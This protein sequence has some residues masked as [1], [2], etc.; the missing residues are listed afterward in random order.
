MKSDLHSVEH[1]FDYFNESVRD[2]LDA[3]NLDISEDTALYLATLLTDRARADRPAPD[4][5]TLAGIHAEAA[6]APPGRS[7]S[8][9][10]ELGDR[11]LYVL[12]CFRQQ[13]DRVRRPV[14]PAY[15]EQMGIA[16]Y[17]QCDRVLKTW[18]ADAFGPVFTDLSRQFS[19]CVDVLSTVK[20]SDAD[21]ERAMSALLVGQSPI[22]A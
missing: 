16:A 12:G 18:F 1:L 14:G 22:E 20:R 10:R 9:Y 8:L 3:S 5:D 11:T 4:I 2:A 13:L 7:A 21:H 19:G 17:G 6:A 15:Y